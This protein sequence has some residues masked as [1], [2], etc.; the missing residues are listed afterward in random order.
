[1][2]TTGEAPLAFLTGATG[3][4]GGRLA[5]A[6]HAQGY[7][8]RCLVRR[9][10]RSGALAA[11][12]AEL[13]VGDVTDVASMRKA[14]AGAALAVHA[15][16]QYDIGVV[17]AA[18][19]ERVNLGGTRNFIEACRSAG[20][21]RAIHVSTTAALGPVPPG[22]EG[23][24]D[25]RY[26]GPYPSE[27]HR[28]KT[29]AHRVAEAAQQDGMPLIV[30]CPAF[31]YGPG[32]EGPAGEYI[33]DVLR[34]RVPG[35]STRPTHFSY[36]HVD[37]VVAGIVAA[38]EHGAPGATYVLGGEYASVDEYTRLIARLAGT[39]V[40]PLRFPPFMVKLTG[41]LMDAVTRL[42]GVR[43]PVSRELAAVGGSGD[44]WLHSHARASRELGYAPRALADGLPETVQDVKAR[45]SG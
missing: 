20:V 17:D 34:H 37:D 30:V 13:V 23:D 7:R 33:A 16:A 9:P 12:G 39:W 31:V 2:S 27:Y 21:A 10:E 36:V 28:T 18:A 11:L 15:A 19:M 43:M 38:A 29:A 6:L 14:A 45:L 42:T 24:E 3:F 22:T 26:D 35:L 44:R 1:M 40:S 32:D 5:A 25:S 8:L 41:S 4:I